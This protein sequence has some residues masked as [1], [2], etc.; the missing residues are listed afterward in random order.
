MLHKIQRYFFLFYVDHFSHIP[1]TDIWESAFGYAKEVGNIVELLAKRARANIILVGQEGVGSLGI[2]KAV[3]KRLKGH[4]ELKNHPIFFLDLND[5]L[6]QNPNG[7]H[8]LHVLAK[9]L[10]EMER[11]GNAVVVLSGMSDVF[12][13]KYTIQAQD[14]LHPFFSSPSVK[15]ITILS[16]EEYHAHIASNKEL[17]RFVEAIQIKGLSASST[18][19]F[20]K[21][22]FGSHIPHEVLDDVVAQTEGIYPH[23]PYPKRAIDI[24][25]GL[26]AEKTLEKEHVARH[27]SQKIG[28]DIHRLKEVHH[29]DMKEA[30]HRRLVNQEQAVQEIADAFVRSRSK[31]ADT[32]H[33]IASLLFTGPR[34]VGKKEAAKAIAQVYFGSRKRIV[35]VHMNQDAEDLP[36]VIAEHPFHVLLLEGLEE[37]PTIFQGYVTDAFGR[38]YSTTNMIVIVTSNEETISEDLRASVDG[39][40]RFVSLN[41]EHVREVA[42]NLLSQLN[43]RLQLEYNVSLEIT[44]ELIGY[45]AQ[46]GYSKEQGA[47]AMPELI[48]ETVQKAAMEAISRGRVV[49]GGKILIDPLRL[50]SA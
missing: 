35:T 8:Q 36:R 28:F 42:H 2:A 26:I 16:D 27:I 46:K 47:H 45:I 43:G 30:L 40:A 44:P 23:I 50:P 39:V 6:A 21:K 22:R 20:L 14:I 29:H 49:P 19:Q 11:M 4:P 25:H 32:K 33:P 15:T 48:Q 34:G 12:A 13:G 3:A 41:P 38:K 24:V 5:I 10:S 17:S 9:T 1:H 18:K 7:I 37:P 31:E